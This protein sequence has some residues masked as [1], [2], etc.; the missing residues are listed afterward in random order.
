MRAL[1]VEDDLH[2][3][4]ALCQ[5]LRHAGYTV[6]WVTNGKAALSAATTES[7]GAMLLDLGLPYLDGLKVLRELRGYGNRVPVL[8]ITARHA[9]EDRIAG[10]DLGAD[11][12]LVKPFHVGEML[13]R[14]RAL[15]RRPGPNVAPVLKNGSL[16]LNPST[17]EVWY[18]GEQRHLSAKE[19]A[20]LYEFV[21]WP[22]VILSRNELE[23]RIYGLNEK[24]ESNAIEFI[25]YSLR[26]KL[27]SGVIKNIRGVGWMIPKA[28]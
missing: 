25:I 19:F 27:D 18:E 14:L 28:Q 13:A 17:H 12:Y 6:D 26:K 10:L 16:S 21:R 8:I 15:A 4:E 5:A 2:I 3:G 23:K 11:D 20:L 9:V 22:G 24:V 1:L 7:Y